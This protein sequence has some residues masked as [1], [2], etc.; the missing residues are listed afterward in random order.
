VSQPEKSLRDKLADAVVMIEKAG[1]EYATARGL[2]WNLQELRKVVL[3]EETRKAEGS[4]MT[5]KETNARCSTAYKTHLDGTSQAIKDELIKK[6]V[7]E[8]WKA[9]WDSL[10]SL[11]SF[12]KTQM[13]TFQE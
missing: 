6:A 3:A 13:E 10:R 7:C 5:E 4:S 8:R 11:I 2:S 9:Q 12:E 1:R